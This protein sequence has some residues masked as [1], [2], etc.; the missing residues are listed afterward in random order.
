MAVH[1]HH[2]VSPKRPRAPAA[3]LS[4]PIF[5]GVSLLGSGVAL[6]L[7]IQLGGK[8]TGGVVKYT[9]RSTCTAQ[10]RD[11][12]LERLSDF[13]LPTTPFGAD[14][15]FQIQLPGQDPDELEHLPKALT[16]PGLFEVRSGDTV[17]ARTLRHAGF[18]LSVTTGT[19]VT[20]VNLDV[21]P[22]EEGLD[23]RID[24]SS[25][26]VESVNG[27][28]LMLTTEE[29]DPRLAVREATERAVA[30]RHPL[31][32]PVELVSAERVDAR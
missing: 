18:Q 26:G 2:E 10:A 7:L 13:G 32:C 15:T 31:P 28:E 14:L 25:V 8:A 21:A 12:M 11:V 19:A 22:P 16:R 23:V 6:F 1:V 27:G 24:G 20:L 9:F 3:I 4:I 17:V 29:K 5:I 30:L